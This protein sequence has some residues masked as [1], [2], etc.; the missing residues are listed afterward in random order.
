MNQDIITN[1]LRDHVLIW[2]ELG[3]LGELKELGENNIYNSVLLS[4]FFLHLQG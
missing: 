3:E 4:L 1:H 2:V